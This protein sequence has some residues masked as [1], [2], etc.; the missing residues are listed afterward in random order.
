[1][2][3]SE[4]VRK[5]LK[6]YLRKKHLSAWGLYKATGIPRSTLCAFLSGRT[7]LIKLH[8][9]LHICEGLDITLIDFFNDPIFK[10]VEQD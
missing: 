10:D 9:L 5:R 6:V 3:L 4:A 2:S 1:M 7:S 8:T